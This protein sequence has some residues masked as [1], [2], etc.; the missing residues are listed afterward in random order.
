MNWH[1][2]K[3]IVNFRLY[4]KD[5]FQSQINIFPRGSLHML[6]E[7]IIH[8][9]S[10]LAILVSHAYTHDGL[11]F[12]TPDEFSQQLA[13]MKHPKGKTIEPHAHQLAKREVLYTNE[14]LIV[15]RG[16]VRIDFFD[17]R[18]TYLKSRILE[19]GDVILLVSGGH[20]LEIL[21]EAELFEVKQGPYSGDHD[22][23]KFKPSSFQINYED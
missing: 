2:Y 21:E 23:I 16:R 8:D 15:K 10:T 17:D 1:V 18:Q 5:G 22:K 11:H 20:G 9:G 4:Y 7:N 19:A 3:N 6:V 13:Y 14:A 12:F